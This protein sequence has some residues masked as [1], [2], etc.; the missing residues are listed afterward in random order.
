MHYEE[1]Y[2]GLISEVATEGTLVEGRNGNTRRLFGKQLEID[3]LKYGLFPLI[4]GRQM[5]IKGIAGE[6]AAFLKGPT[7]DNDFK[8]QGCNYWSPWADEK[9]NLRVDYGN[10]WLDFN[11]INQ[12][13]EIIEL[14]NSQPASRRLLISGWDPSTI[15]NSSLPCCHYAYQFSVN[16]NTMDIIW[17]QR[18]VDLMIGLPSDIVLAAIFLILMANTTGYSPGRI[19]MQ[20]GDCHVYENHF[21]QMNTYLSSKL[22]TPPQYV[23]NKPIYDFD[24]ADLHILKYKHSNRIDFEVNA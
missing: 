9:G 1:R 10:K 6:M 21:D 13:A 4:T 16:E 2:K 12:I 17:V 15:E 3:S 22:H 11:G 18:S 8:D 23:L 14:I 19:I 7:H 5:F 24:G 20:L